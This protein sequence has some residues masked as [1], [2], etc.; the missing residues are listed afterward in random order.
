M[1]KEIVI[2]VLGTEGCHGSKE[3]HGLKGR[4]MCRQVPK[5]DVALEG[6]MNCRIECGSM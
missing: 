6:G 2:W 4:Y 5:G 1:N 3:G